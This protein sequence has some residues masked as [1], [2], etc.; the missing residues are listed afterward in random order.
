MYVNVWKFPISRHTNPGVHNMYIPKAR[1]AMLPMPGQ[2]IYT[3]A[4][5]HFETEWQAS[6]MLVCIV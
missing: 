1:A 3:Y 4:I 6:K 5:V 2:V